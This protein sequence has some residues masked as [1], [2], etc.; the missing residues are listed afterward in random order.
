MIPKTDV[1]KLLELYKHQD[2]QTT[3]LLEITKT[4]NDLNVRNVNSIERLIGLVEV[5]TKDVN[6][7]NERVLA[8]EETSKE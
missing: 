3:D 6:R 5:L 4:I 2:K 7:L 1:E 8:L